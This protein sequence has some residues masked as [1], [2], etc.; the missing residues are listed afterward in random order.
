M[1]KMFIMTKL[2][3]LA[4]IAVEAVVIVHL[5]IATNELEL[6]LLEM[7]TMYEQALNESLLLPDYGNDQSR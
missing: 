6:Y 3:L 4:I 1:L 2:T 5:L 7:H